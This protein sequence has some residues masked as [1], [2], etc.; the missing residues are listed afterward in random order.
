MKIICYR[1]LA[2]KLGTAN[3]SVT[4]RSAL[5]LG[6]DRYPLVGQRHVVNL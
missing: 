4:D 5:C 6:A 2:E 3:R 1:G